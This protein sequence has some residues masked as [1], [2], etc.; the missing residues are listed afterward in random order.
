LSIFCDTCGHNN[1]ETAKFCHKCGKKIFSLAPDG[2]LKPGVI[3]D[4]RYEIK[5]SIKSGGMGAVYEALDHRFEK[6]PCA[7]KEMLRSITCSEDQEY[8]INRFKKEALILHNLKH[9]NLP[10]VKDYFVES[11]RYYLVMDYIEGKDLET[12]L[13]G[14]GERGVPEKLVI[15][16]GKQILDVLDYLHNQSP[17]IVYRDL[18]PANIM[19]RSSDRRIMLV[20]F[21]IARTIDPNSQTVKTSICTPAFA[22]QE[23]FEGR[24]EP[25][26][27]IYSL[28]ATLHCLLTGK[29]PRKPFAFE[30][31]RKIR[32]SA[33]KE[34]EAIIMCA[35]KMSVEKRYRNAKA[36]KNALENLEEKQEIA[37]T[38]SIAPAPAKPSLS[39]NPV[40]YQSAY[41]PTVFSE[42]PA[43]APPVPLQKPIPAYNH[44]I[45]PDKPASLPGIKRKSLN[46]PGKKKFFLNTKINTKEVLVFSGIA[47]IVCSFFL[48]GIAGPG[49]FCCLIIAG[50]LITLIPFVLSSYWY[51][52]GIVLSKQGR[53]VEANEYYRKVLQLNPNKNAWNG[54][55]N[56][57]SNQGKYKEAV[58]CFDMALKIDGRF[59]YA[60]YNKGKALDSQGMYDEAIRC[61]K[62]AIE[63]D[64]AYTLA[65]EKLKQLGGYNLYKK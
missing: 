9:P 33:S 14:Y 10:G 57:M 42:I 1:R 11:G 43:S 20:D 49:W 47:V 32:P 48:A 54:K 38:P 51:D 44:P 50:I 19:L 26:T 60:W 35:L 5:R 64:P 61:Y 15:Q 55:G 22:P 3:L 2:T 25:R 4:R 12:I 23:L 53:Y 31:L 30:P 58:V 63:I 24:P 13:Q 36:M 8:F 28:G 39:V 52:R 41:I 65:I 18:K 37:V 21:G 46:V 6:R 34:I 45:V 27:D 56:A 40:K 17:P 62:T 7:V 16:W 29:I 59:K